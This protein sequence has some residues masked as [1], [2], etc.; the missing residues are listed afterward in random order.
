MKN[1]HFQLFFEIL[2]HSV[3]FQSINQSLQRQFLRLIKINLI[4]THSASK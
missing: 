1:H 2:T 3:I 4:S